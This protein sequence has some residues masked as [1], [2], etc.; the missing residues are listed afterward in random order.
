MAASTSVLD[1]LNIITAVVMSIATA[2]NTAFVVILVRVTKKYTRITGEIL[3]AAQ[4]QAKAAQTQANAAQAQASA[5]S[6]T[7]SALRQQIEEQLGLGRTAVQTI[8]TSAMKQIEYWKSMEISFA[9]SRT[10]PPTEDLIPT[11]IAS[12]IE[13]ARRISREG[14]EHLSGVFD[15]LRLARNEIE[16]VKLAGRQWP[17]PGHFKSEADG[18]RAKKF[19]DMAFI[20][21]QNAQKHLL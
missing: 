5:A 13:H 15:N 14:A 8:I 4:A 19:V 20:E 3:E 17:L 11:T 21:L 1:T 10:L 6:E 16:A 12:A 7:I 2:V 18:Q 9:T